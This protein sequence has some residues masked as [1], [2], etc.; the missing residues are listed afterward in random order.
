MSA[1][2]VNTSVCFT[3]IGML[4]AIGMLRSQIVKM[5]LAEAGLMGFL[6]GILG[7]ATGVILARVLFLGMTTM[8]GYQLT[9]VLAND[10]LIITIIVAYIVSQFAAIIPSWRGSNLR[11]LEAIHHE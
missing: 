2:V 9:F 4:R 10:A 8:S 7:L 11:I 3:G 6:G 5:I 1:A